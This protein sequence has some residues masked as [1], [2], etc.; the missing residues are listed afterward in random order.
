M[1]IQKIQPE[2]VLPLLLCAA[3]TL[4]ILPFAIMRFLSGEM[5]IGVIDSVIVVSMASLAVFVFRTHKVRAASIYLALLCTTGA[6]VTVYLKGPMQVFWTY[7]A[8]MVAFYLIHPREALALFVVA[9]AALLP[10]LYTHM[11]LGHLGAVM[12]TLLITNSIAY[13]FATQTLLHQEQL[14][15]LA[16]CDPLTGTGNRRGLLMEMERVAALRNRIGT[17]CSLLIIDLDLFKNINDKHGHGVGDDVLVKVSNRIT[18]RIRQSDSLY[19]IGGEEFV[20]IM[21]NENIRDAGAL[22]QDLC[23]HIAEEP[24]SKNINVTISIGVAELVSGE[25][26]KEW[27]GRADDALYDA[28]NKGR[29]R[30]CLARFPHERE[31][32]LSVTGSQQA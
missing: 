15:E 8:L 30:A 11:E 25:T 21:N 7:P 19:R 32:T 28:K 17:P 3:G 31:N 18:N 29:N 23:T 14:M 6:L 13:S 20:V 4:G 22:A 1:R 12:V 24:C 16:A 9:V 10:P 5:L 26:S 2:E 27:L